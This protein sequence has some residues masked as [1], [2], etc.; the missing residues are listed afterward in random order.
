MRYVLLL[1]LAIF[2]VAMLVTV[3]MLVA[4]AAGIGSIT[5]TQLSAMLVLDL[6]IY[7]LGSFVSDHC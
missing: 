6:V 1:V 5:G 3:G 7:G 2:A 4:I